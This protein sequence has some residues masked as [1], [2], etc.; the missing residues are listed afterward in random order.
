MA[1]W[2]VVIIFIIYERTL[3]VLFIYRVFKV[4]A[5]P[6][7]LLLVVVTRQSKLQDTGLGGLDG[8]CGY[9]PPCKTCMLPF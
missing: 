2:I 8:G 4:E 7:E 3:L 5:G 6:C 9:V 1:V